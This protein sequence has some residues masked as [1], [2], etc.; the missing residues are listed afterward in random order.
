MRAV[1][2]PHTS[3]QAE[4]SAVLDTQAWSLSQPTTTSPTVF[5]IPAQYRP[6]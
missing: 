3:M 1:T 6:L 4:Y 5:R 2:R